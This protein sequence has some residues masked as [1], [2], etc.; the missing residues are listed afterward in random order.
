MNR[1]ILTRVIVNVAVLV[2]AYA[3]LYPLSETINLGLDLKGGVLL[4]MEVEISDIPA[5]KVEEEVD[6]AMQIIRNR[7]DQFG[8]TSPTISRQGKDKIVVELPGEKDPERAKAVIGK[9]ARLE[10]RLVNDDLLAAATAG[11]VPD[12]YE[13]LYE[14]IRDPITHLR[15]DTRPWLVEARTLMTGENLEKAFIQPDPM[16]NSPNVAFQFNSIGARQFGELTSRN[17]NRKLAIILDG[18][19][20][21]APVI[22]TAITGGNGVI[23]GRF[24]FDDAKELSVVLN[25]G[26]LP[27]EV[28]IIEERAIGPSLGLDS[29]FK[30]LLASA[31]GF[32]LTVAFVVAWY[33]FSGLIA[34]VALLANVILVLGAMALMKG[35]LTLPGIAGL[36]L[37]V[38]MAVDANVLVYERIKEEMRAG[39][40]V[41]T[42]IDAGF[43]R[44]FWTIFDSNLTTLITAVVLYKFGAGPVRG[45]AVTLIV[46]ILASMF[47]A[48]Y[49]CKTLF[50]IITRRPD[51]VKISI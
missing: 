24:T 42:A 50:L 22:R 49:G 23:E 43:A 30:G 3:A 27:S 25:A 17:V 31:I 2:A 4:S 39:R 16:T 41:R 7:V 36:L 19:V 9:T 13:L 29:I 45:F 10:F 20:Q 21:S 33:R 40:T 12:G 26:A 15:V 37:T 51:V 8:V 1:K 35:T 44:A 28:R 38:A 11:K 47:T 6:K 18:V 5:D 46:G 32:A 48:L 34:T 14:H